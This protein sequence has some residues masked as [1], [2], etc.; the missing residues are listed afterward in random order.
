MRKWGL[1]LLLVSILF[2][3]CRTQLQKYQWSKIKTQKLP[4]AADQNSQINKFSEK[5]TPPQQRESK[6]SSGKQ[7]N[8]ATDNCWKS[9]DI[10]IEEHCPQSNCISEN[11]KKDRSWASEWLEDGWSPQSTE[12]NPSQRTLLG[13]GLY[14]LGEAGLL[15]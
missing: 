10:E 2:I 13:Q 3:F 11:L 4:S 12:L 6:V 9:L 8:N 7:E 5:E 1:A 15:E 14:A